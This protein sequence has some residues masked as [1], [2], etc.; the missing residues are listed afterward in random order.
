MTK[1]VVGVSA[2]IVNARWGAWQR[3]AVLLP[4]AYVVRLAAAGAI[5]VLLPPGPE[6]AAPLLARLDALVLSGGGDM[7]PSTYQAGIHARTYG[8]DPTRDRT[9]L[10]LLAEADRVGLPVLAIC[11]GMQ[12]LNVARGGTLHQH[13]PDI[14][15]HEQHSGGRGEYGRHD[16]VVDA[17]TRLG[18]VVGAGRLNV[19]THHHQA[20]DG[21]G[22]GLVVTATADD[23][24]IEA[25]EDP[26]RFVV[27]VQWHPEIDDDLRLFEALV[28]AAAHV[29]GR[30]GPV[31]RVGPGG[32]PS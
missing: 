1:P 32:S 12:V 8:I 11:R 26:T 15:G 13:I 24:T 16:V 14:V 18:R 6:T 23:G 20:I 17:A 4:E 25:V 27:G 29:P 31:E 5:P 10:A 22:A 7:D 2:N 21:L 3:P 19:A 30:A 9:E 28:Q